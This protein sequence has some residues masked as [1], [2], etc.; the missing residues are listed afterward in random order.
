MKSNVVKIFTFA[1]LLGVLVSA[2]SGFAAC[3]M[4]NLGA[5][6]IFLN[7]ETGAVGRF[8]NGA[9]TSQVPSLVEHCAATDGPFLMLA[10]GIVSPQVDAN[11]SDLVFDGK[12]EA[13]RCSFKYSPFQL[14]E[15]IYPTASLV[16]RQ[17]QILKSCTYLSVADLEGRALNFKVD[18][19]ACKVTN[20]NRGYIRME[21]DYCFLRLRPFN[22]VSISVA[23]KDECRS[24]EFLKTHGINPQDIPFALNSYLSGDDSGL[25]PDL[26]ALGTRQGRLYIQPS[27]Q[28]MALT[29]DN[30]E[31]NPRFPTDFMVDTHMGNISITGQNNTY[32]IITSLAASNLGQ[33]S[34]KQGNCSTPNNFMAPVAA[35]M[36]LYRIAT[37]GKKELVDSWW[38]ADFIFPQWQGLLKTVP[39]NLQE[40]HIE[41]GDEYEL[42]TLFVDP[43]DD[44]TMATQDFFQFLI[45]IQGT[46]GTAGIDP[47][48]SLPGF[49]SSRGLRPVAGLPSLSSGD[50]NQIV[51]QAIQSLRMFGDN[52]Q[53]PSYYKKVC[54]PSKSSCADAGKTKFYSKLTTR[55]KVLEADASSGALKLGQYTY[56]RESPVLGNYTQSFQQDPAVNCEAPK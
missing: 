9:K 34:C 32:T 22:R 13:P 41:A 33:N 21:G 4:Q 10:V 36:E 38:Y 23:L 42:V 1:T 46:L 19:K 8:S 50:A 12:M 5:L 17:H 52:N 14:K 24:P 48:S 51:E 31:E 43:L 29:E 16:A 44:F 56:K 47:I 2:S 11:F 45:N 20:D 6:N 49:T 3:R 18:Q 25:S 7:S 39:H 30:G 54:N 27:E 40:T 28:L 26:T 55:F 35:E 53:W 37:N 15:P